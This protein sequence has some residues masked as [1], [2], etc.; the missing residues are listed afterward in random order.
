MGHHHEKPATPLPPTTGDGSHTEVLKRPSLLQYLGLVVWLAI[1][2]PLF[3]KVG[4]ISSPSRSTYLTL[5]TFAY[6]A[7][8]FAGASPLLRRTNRIRDA[9]YCR[10]ER[11]IASWRCDSAILKEYN[12]GVK[13][14]F[15]WTWLLR[16]GAFRPGTKGYIEFR[17]FPE[18]VQVDRD[19]MPLSCVHPRL[20][21]STIDEIE[22]LEDP[23]CIEFTIVTRAT[24]GRL[25][26]K[27][28]IP[29]PREATEAAKKVSTHMPHG[30]PFP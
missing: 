5:M 19:L 21:G 17:F 25:E 28:S 23:R 26:R 15:P 27:V 12:R 18:G 16:V 6:F 30:W 14:R 1:P 22:I 3:M 29:F 9:K 24:H 13:R 8:A 2:V 7:W 4:A 11:E 10:P 20:K